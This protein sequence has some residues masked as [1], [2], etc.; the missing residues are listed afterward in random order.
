MSGQWTMR[1][2]L[3]RLT[4]LCLGFSKKAENLK[5]AVAVYFAW[6]N[7]VHVHGSLKTTPAVAAGIESK[8]W[9]VAELLKAA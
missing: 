3:R 4:R 2:F 8:A 1:T 9:T 7:F 5:A 6:Y